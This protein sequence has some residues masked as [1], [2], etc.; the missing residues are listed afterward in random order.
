M[1]EHRF[2]PGAVDEDI[3]DW[4]AETQA[5]SGDNLGPRR[6]ADGTGAVGE[7]EKINS[8]VLLIHPDSGPF[9]P[10]TI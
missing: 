1:M 8:P 10:V 9:L 3:Y 7:L 5:D 2:Y 6:N 4:F